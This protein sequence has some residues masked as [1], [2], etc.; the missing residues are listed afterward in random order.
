MHLYQSPSDLINL[1]NG[2]AYLGGEVLIGSVTKTNTQYQFSITDGNAAIPVIYT[3]TLP[4]M[5][6]EG[7]DTI[8]KGRMVSGVLQAQQVLAKHDEYYRAEN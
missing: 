2:S 1:N 8:V 3:G 5:F 4:V 6:K 7:R